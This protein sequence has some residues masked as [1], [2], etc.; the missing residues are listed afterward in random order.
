MTISFIIAAYNAEAYIAQ[1]I[2][3]CLQLHTNEKEIIVIND[4]STDETLKICKTFQKQYSNI[5][6]INQSNQGVSAARNE[7]IKMAHGDW[8]LFIDAD[9]TINPKELDNL[10]FDLSKE[11]KDIPIC[12]FSSNF[13]YKDK[14][15]LHEVQ[16]NIY[17]TDYFINSAHFQLASWN[18][19]FKRN[20]IKSNDILFPD[21]IICAE[22][23]NFNLKCL[24][25]SQYILSYNYTI[26]NYNRTN[27][28]SASAQK[29]NVRWIKSRLKSANDLLSFCNKRKIPT[30]RIFQQ[31]KRLYESYMNDATTNISLKEKRIFFQEEYAKTLFL[32]PEF[33]HLK[34]FR[35]CHSWFF[36][37]NI[38]FSIHKKIY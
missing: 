23:Q 29:H 7:G 35:I 17:T 27:S 11:K 38:L 30:I 26:Y 8:I 18:Y 22:D 19:L 13:V 1:C 25:C 33:R 31:I 3:C 10:L 20:L 5:I 16:N 4:G 12:T 37:G 32:L 14:T 34:K 36:L 24:C 28:D 15:E 21:N 9:D 2:E 6:I